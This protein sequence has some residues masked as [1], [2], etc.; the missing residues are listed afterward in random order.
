MSGCESIEVNVEAYLS[1][2]PPTWRS[3]DDG[4][5]L[6]GES[7]YREEWSNDAV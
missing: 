1:P 4:I 7:Q 2:L 3:S 6:T 5:L